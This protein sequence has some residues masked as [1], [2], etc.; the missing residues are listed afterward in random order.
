MEIK[1]IL[2]KLSR[3]QK[4]QLCSGRDFWHTMDLKR[5]GLPSVMMCDGPHGLRCQKEG[6]D[7]LGL[8]NSVPATCFPT[9][10]ISACSWDTELLYKIGNAIAEE[11]KAMDVSLVLGPGV[12]IKRDPLCGRNFEYF[13]EDP[14]VSGKMGAAFIRGVE[15]TGVG[16]CV[17]HFALNNQEY[18]RF[19]GNS[20]IDERTMR[21]IYLAPFEI[22]VKEGKPASVMCAYN[23]VNG[24]HCSDSKLL[25]TDILRTQWGFDGLVVTDWGAMND[26]VAAIKA[27]CDLNMPG[28]SDYMQWDVLDA[29]KRGTLTEE[30]LDLCAARVL[31]MMERGSRI[32]KKACDPDAH[33][34]LAREAAGQSAVLLKNADSV[35]PL[36]PDQKIALIGAMADKPRFQGA[37]SSHIN[38]TKLVSAREAMPSALYSPGCNHDGSTNEHLLEAAAATAAEAE[39]AI[40]F[41][42][43]TDSY[44]SEGFDREDLQMPEGHLRM[45]DAVCEANKNTVVVLCCGGVVAC[46]WADRVKGILYMGLGGQAAGEAVWDLLTGRVNPSGKL[47]ETWV[48]SYHDCPTSAYYRGQKDPQ[49][50]ESVYVGYRYYGKAGVKV[51]WPFG[52]GLSYTKFQYSD[53]KIEGKSVSCSVRNVGDRAGK[54]VVQLYVSA[55]QSGIFRPV[56][57]LKGFAKVNLLPGQTGVV[58]FS[59]DDRAFSLW[60]DGWKVPEGEYTV[61]ICSDSQTVQLQQSIWVDG[62]QILAPVWQKDS[63]YDKPVGSPDE[64]VWKLIY[65]REQEKRVFEKGYFT[66][67]DTVLELK[68]HAWIMKFLYKCVELVISR[69]FGYKK[70]YSNPEFRM[71]MASSTDSP[72]R[73]IQIC[74]GIRGGLIKGLLHIANG[75][76]FLGL[77]TILGIKK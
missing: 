48:D 32:E 29:L 43:L 74:G 68:D 56:Q 17:K 30:E 47:A 55:P 50:R 13:S 21:E 14:Y 7:H 53:L 51:R 77:L 65:P 9:A 69:P 58:S 67:D 35:L 34:E 20:Q 23:K 31:K 73:N 33:H 11:A 37:G 4:V 57:E 2:N 54:E 15:D 62:D 76:S 39:V 26:R 22:A 75:H 10:S 60:E 72:L 18:K 16:S 40:V 36:K 52:Y 63:W 27:G 12:N 25:L 59:L 45:I 6:A 44:E 3:K 28:G 8:N 70:D 42:G 19:N 38:P 24:E 41:A 71:L 46:P 64:D 66:M 49:Y 61:K 5:F 1:E